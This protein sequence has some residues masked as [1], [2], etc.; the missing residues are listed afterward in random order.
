MQIQTQIGIFSQTNKTKIRI[1]P[2]WELNLILPT[3]NEVK[4]KFELNLLYL[5]PVASASVFKPFWALRTSPKT[6]LNDDG[7]DECNGWN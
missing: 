7:T 2:A 3:E 6:E 5:S 1:T 4:A